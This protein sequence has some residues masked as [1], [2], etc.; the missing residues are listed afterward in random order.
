MDLRVDLAPMSI[1]CESLSRRSCIQQGYTTSVGVIGA[2]PSVIATIC[3]NGPT[4]YDNI[5]FQSVSE[6]SDA[7][8][9]PSCNVQAV[10]SGQGCQHSIHRFCQ[11]KGYT[12]GFSVLEYDS[13][14]GDGSVSCAQAQFVD[15]GL[16]YNDCTERPA[17]IGQMV[18]GGAAL[19]GDLIYADAIVNNF[20]YPI[21]IKKMS[22][23]SSFV[24]DDP[25]SYTKDMCFYLN[26]GHTYQSDDND[27]GEFSC[28]YSEE[29]AS[30]S[31]D[32]GSSR[33]LLLKP[34]ERFI[35]QGSPQWGANGHGNHGEGLYAGAQ[36]TIT[37]LESSGAIGMRRIRFPRWDTSYSVSGGNV[38]LAVP[39]GCN[40]NDC[41][42]TP[43]GVPPDKPLRNSN[44]WYV[45][46]NATAIRGVS[47]FLGSA[48]VAGT[49][50]FKGCVRV[51]QQGGVDIRSPVC[52]DVSDVSFG[53]STFN[54]VF[55][56]QQNGSS[57]INLDIDVPT[58]ALIGID[59]DLSSDS[60]GS[61][62]FGAYLWLQ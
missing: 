24:A 8:K 38:P 6:L 28:T 17:K 29:Q 26:R 31:I 10:G 2:N 36:I 55:G 50:R 62:D 4:V 32:F 47:L 51:V 53:P 41:A 12:T 49:Q 7:A 22:P 13:N 27:D 39:A 21:L 48:K 1:Y 11:T 43:L 56:A 54:R 40:T 46:S 25:A 15:S 58:G 37:P 3:L 61:M 20:N 9:D 16:R 57:F 42:S 35:F 44:D 45:V 19:A 18:M 59:F 5:H 34:G 60:P 33:G 14:S 30:P 52:F 23:V